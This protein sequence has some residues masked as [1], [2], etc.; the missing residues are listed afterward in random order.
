VLYA[1][2]EGLNLMETRK[3]FADALLELQKQRCKSAEKGEV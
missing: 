2:N 3:L 1:S